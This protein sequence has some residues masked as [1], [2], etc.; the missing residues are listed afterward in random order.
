[1]TATGRRGFVKLLVT[2]GAAPTV[3]SL[4]GCDGGTMAMDAG[5][6]NDAGGGGADAGSEPTDAGS[7]PT[8]AGSE[9]TD[10]GSAPAC[11]S[12]TSRIGTNHGHTLTVPTEHLTAGTEQRYD[13]RGSSAHPH[14][15]NV[16]PDH[17]T[18]LRATGTVAI[19]SSRDSGHTHVVT[20]T[21]VA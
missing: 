10:G 18:T 7:E 16:T 9:P 4:V 13:I 17:W 21:C 12:M 3:L 11:G 1:M 5:A 19:T 6:G 8:D 15:L 20:L 14:T 2:V